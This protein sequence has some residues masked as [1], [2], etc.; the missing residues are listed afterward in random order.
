MEGEKV[1]GRARR[2]GLSAWV[3]VVVALTV[4]TGPALEAQAAPLEAARDTLDPAGSDTLGLADAVALA[5]RTHPALEAA[6][7]GLAGAAA[8]ERE[9]RAA[10]YPSL[11]LSGSAVRYE[12]PMIVAPL[13]AFDPQAAPAFDETLLQGEATAAYTLFDGGGRGARIDRARWERGAAIRNLDGHTVSD[14]AD[15]ARMFLDQ[16]GI[17]EGDVPCLGGTIP[18]LDLRARPPERFFP[19]V[20]RK[21]ATKKDDRPI[22]SSVPL[23]LKVPQSILQLW[24]RAYQKGAKGQG[25]CVSIARQPFVRKQYGTS[26]PPHGQ[27]VAEAGCRSHVQRTVKSRVWA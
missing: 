18:K 9:A 3:T 27:R 21:P 2:V 15:C 11:R 7:A 8:A 23:T 26:V 10:R 1:I 4:A 25:D 12:E 20:F 16:C 6:S 13:H 24:W 5:L 17:S 22:I 19:D 14:L